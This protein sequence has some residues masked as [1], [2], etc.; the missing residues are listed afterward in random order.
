MLTALNSAAVKISAH[1]F[2]WILYAF[3]LYIYIKADDT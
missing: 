2:Q 3:Q 1:V